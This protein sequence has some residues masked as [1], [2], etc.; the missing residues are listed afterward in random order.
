MISR[1]ILSTLLASVFGTSLLLAPVGS[2][3]AQ[4]P[5]G[6]KISVPRNAATNEAAPS[7]ESGVVDAQV[8]AISL[9]H[10][11]QAKL[12][13]P[14]AQASMDERRRRG[15]K[16]ARLNRGHS[17][18]SEDPTPTLQP[19]TAFCTQMAAERYR[20]IAEAGGWPTISKPIGRDAAADDVNVLR[21]RLV[22]E[23]DLS[24]AAAA[25]NGWDD[26]LTEAI[27]NFQRRAGLEQNGE[28]DSAT[29]RALNVPADLRVRELEESAKRI[30]DIAIPFDQRYVVVNI[31][32]ASVEAV[33]GS[34]V[35]ERHA[36]VAGDADHPSPQLIALIRGI[37]FNPTWTIPRSIVENEVIPKLKKN[38]NYLRRAKIYLLD[39]RGHK[40]KASRIHWSDEKATVFTFRQ[41]PGNKN[42]LGTLR[43]DM[44]NRQAVYMHDTPSRRLFAADYRFL[45]HGCV[46]VDGVYDLAAWLMS[47]KA[48]KHGHWDRSAIDEAVRKGRQKRVGLAQPVPAAWIYLDA[49]ASAGGVVHYRPDVYDVDGAGG[50]QFQYQHARQTVKSAA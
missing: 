28:V 21:G 27:S 4:E 47:T 13:A 14:R 46:R 9:A 24:Q 20:H 34:R 10:A 31:P 30:A 8:C 32:S 33:E 42:S 35:V 19:S 38:P 36:A 40:L 39:R 48:K 41:K 26:A 2:S 12:F 45:S 43:I 22:V 25:G 3:K 5:S 37:T 23:G 15:G 6:S 44:P 1:R 18:L 7:T 29:L 16:A 17:A 50:G 49:W 11:S